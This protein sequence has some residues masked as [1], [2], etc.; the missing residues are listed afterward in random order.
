[1]RLLG[2][3]K[4]IGEA[5]QWMTSTGPVT[6]YPV[7]FEAEGNMFIGDLF[8]SA[9][10][11]TNRGICPNAV[12]YFTLEF[13][14]KDVKNKEGVVMFQRQDVRFKDFQLA[15][16]NLVGAQAPANDIDTTGA[17]APNG[18]QAPAGETVKVDV[19]PAEQ[20]QEAETKGTDLSF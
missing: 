12:G 20:A 19:A 14:I 10:T 1:M 3:I 16:A 8:A 5:R 17:P 4:S 11:I 7:T 13:K 15:N 9:S 18:S 2:I 6:I